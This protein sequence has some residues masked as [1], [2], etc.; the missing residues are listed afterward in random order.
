MRTGT[1]E[2]LNKLQNASDLTAFFEEY[3]EELITEAVGGYLS[4][5]MEEA[6]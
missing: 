1:V 3:C 4:A 2:L 6:A 5:I